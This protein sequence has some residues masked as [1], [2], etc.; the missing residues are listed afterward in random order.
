MT[1]GVCPELLAAHREGRT[2]VLICR[3]T[4]GS[5]AEMRL[6]AP[7]LYGTDARM[8]DPIRLLTFYP[9]NQPPLAFRVASD[10][11]EQITQVLRA[12]FFLEDFPEPCDHCGAEEG[13]KLYYTPSGTSEYLC[14]ACTLYEVQ[15]TA[16]YLELDH[17]IDQA[18][19]TWMQRW[20]ETTW[21]AGLGEQL[22]YIGDSVEE[23]LNGE[24]KMEGA[25]A[26]KEEENARNP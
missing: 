21:R 9:D 26:H 24:S 13:V 17:L 11:L 23:R 15:A 18:V 20:P 5:T 16:A 8:R 12:S 6:A 1:P 25:S 10:R 7:T 3:R 4:D 2:T 19:R 22:S 14:P